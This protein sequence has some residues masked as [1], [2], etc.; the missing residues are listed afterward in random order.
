MP[1]KDIWLEILV[2]YAAIQKTFSLAAAEAQEKDRHPSCQWIWA[3]VRHNSKEVLATSHCRICRPDLSRGLHSPS[4]VHCL[5]SACY[6]GR[7]AHPETGPSG[8]RP[9]RKP[10]RM[11][12]RKSTTQ[13]SSKSG[14]LTR[15]SSLWDQKETGP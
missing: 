7:G 11:S 12:L 2:S 8:R 3:Q 15:P 13:D 4:L 14:A 9:Y 6:G 1:S 10:L 5:V